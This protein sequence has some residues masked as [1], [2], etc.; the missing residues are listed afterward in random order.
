MVTD[1]HGLSPSHSLRLIISPIASMMTWPISPTSGKRTFPSSDDASGQLHGA[2]GP[3]YPLLRWAHL[4][5]PCTVPTHVVPEF[6]EALPSFLP[7]LPTISC[8]TNSSLVAY[9]SSS[10]FTYPSSV[11]QSSRSGKPPSSITAE[12]LQ[13]HAHVPS[14]PTNFQRRAAFVRRESA[15]VWA[16]RLQVPR[17]DPFRTRS[18]RRGFFSIQCAAAYPLADPSTAPIHSASFPSL[19]QQTASIQH[20]TAPAPQAPR[21]RTILYPIPGANIPCRHHRSEDW[22]RD[23]TLPPLGF[24]SRPLDIT[25]LKYS[26]LVTG[27]APPVQLI[28]YISANSC[29]LQLSFSLSTFISRSPPTFLT[30]LE[31]WTNPFVLYD[32]ITLVLNCTHFPWSSHQ[33]N[34]NFFIGK[35]FSSF[36]FFIFYFILSIYLFTSR[37][38]FHSIIRVRYQSW[39]QNK[40]LCSVLWYYS[41]FDLYHISP[42]PW[43]IQSI[44]TSSNPWLHLSIPHF[45]H[46]WLIQPIALMQSM[47]TRLLAVLCFIYFF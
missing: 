44:A 30:S 5:I 28:S 27:S 4:V 15:R 37:K 38:H 31:Y 47:A 32:D 18:V 14:L 17:S 42:I 6:I 12:L 25:R 43:L 16:L 11:F 33:F 13:I 29:F 35:L 26:W 1:S 36:L 21:D 3:A 40:S 19:S 2:S 8:I 24:P 34:F 23:C 20:T 39:V 9:S 22:A 10:Y 7:S 41:I 45:I 46:P